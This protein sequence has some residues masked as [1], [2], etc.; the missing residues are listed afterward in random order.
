VTPYPFLLL[1]FNLFEFNLYNLFL[2]YSDTFVALDERL[3]LKSPAK[4][5]LSLLL[6]IFF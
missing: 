4:R 3:I 5:H 2:E 6:L 1:V